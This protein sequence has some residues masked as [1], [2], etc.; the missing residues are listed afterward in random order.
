MIRFMRGYIQIKIFGADPVRTLNLFVEHRIGFWQVEHPDDMT[1]ICFIY[2]K[3]FAAAK[4]FSLHS[5]SGITL[6][7]EYSATKTFA[8]LRKRPILLCGIVL[9][10]AFAMLL[11]NYVWTI[12]IEGN[13]EIPTQELR[14]HL[15]QIG[16][17]F[18]AWGPSFE[19]QSLKFQMINRIEKLA[20]IGI[21]RRGGRVTV[22][23]SEREPK[24]TNL[25]RRVF[26]NLIACRPGILT[27]VNIYNGFAEV[28]SGDAVVTGQILVSGMADWTTHTQITR[29]L[30][31]IYAMT[32]HQ[33]SFCVPATV[34]KKC[35]TGKEFRQI[36]LVLGR[37]RIKLSGNSGISYPSCDKMIIRR[38]C[39]LPG[40]YTFPLILETV[41][42]REYQTQTVKLPQQEAEQHLTVFSEAYVHSQMVAGTI[43]SR[44]DTL[45]EENGIYRLDAAIFCEEMI[46]RSRQGA[47][48]KEVTDGTND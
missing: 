39:T 35:Y 37:K 33:N 41:V 14:Q 24:A 42:F 48:N 23:V 17:R 19:Q 27:S 44:N 5:M 16:V 38:V 30:G 2:K 13:K 25:D 1:V 20:W 3:D 28:K 8:G 7:K 9:A 47:L 22:S 11:Q 21:N 4:K 29:S 6:L 32:L 46:A 34:T 31:E 18:G 45:T 36:S 43:L 10:C 15:E 12:E 26:T 40:G